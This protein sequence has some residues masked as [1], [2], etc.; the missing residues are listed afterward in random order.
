MSG[1]DLVEVGVR[2]TAAAREAVPGGEVIDLAVLPGG[3]SGITLSGR[4]VTPEG[5]RPVVVKAT[6]PG[7]RPVGRHDVLRQGDLL[8]ALYGRPRVGVPEILFSRREDP[9]L[10][11]MDFVAGECHEPVLDDA[12]DPRP[13]DVITGRARS[14]V[15]MMAALHAVDPADLDLGDEPIYGPAD[16]LARWRPTMAAVDP[17][18][19]P[20]ADDLADCLA[21]TVP[22]SLPARVVHGDFRLGNVLCEGPTAR[23]VIDW[24]IWS[25]ADP[26]VDLGWFLVMCDHRNHPGVGAPAAGMPDTAGLVSAY[27]EAVGTVPADM[28][29]F[30]ALASYKMAAIMGHN[31]RRHREGRYHDPFQE[32]LPPTIMRLVDHGLEVLDEHAEAPVSG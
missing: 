23:A 20:R 13:A 4:L 2:A 21:D 6:P 11:G 27:A 3:H 22:T 5:G 28:A 25:L 18:L 15:A 32:R 1:L 31:L 7:R 24:E 26:R 16:E 8:A 14:T 19:R 17:E 9:P 30:E 12:D 10:V 29:W